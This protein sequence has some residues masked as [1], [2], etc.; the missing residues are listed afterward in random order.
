MTFNS[1]GA[2]ALK[3]RIAS[4]LETKPAPAKASRP[5]VKPAPRSPFSASPRPRVSASAPARPVWTP[6]VRT[7]TAADAIPDA[8]IM[9]LLRR[10]NLDADAGRVRIL[11]GQ[12]LAT[13][14]PGTEWRDAWPDFVADLKKLG[15]SI[16]STPLPVV[17]ATSPPGDVVV[18]LKPAEPAAEAKPADF[19]VNAWRKRTAA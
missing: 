18:K 5:K 4:L 15:D 7:G 11:F 17:W 19:D 12:H 14:P 1:P 13:C 2:N 16:P 10:E 3:A 6:P 9:F 8:T